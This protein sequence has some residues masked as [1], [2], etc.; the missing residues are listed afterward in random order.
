MSFKNIFISKIGWIAA[1]M[2]M[3]MFSS[4]L[5]Q[6]RL[7]IA[8]HTG[9]VVLP[10]ATI[11]NCICWLLYAIVREKK[12]WPLIICNVFGISVSFVT[13]ITAIIY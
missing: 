13:V 10:I 2:A 6:I 9:S 1:T 11:L 5:D 8:G 12:D 7:N 3:I 4:Y